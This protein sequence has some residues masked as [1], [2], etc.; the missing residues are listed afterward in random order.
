[1]PAQF[2]PETRDDVTGW[3]WEGPFATLIREAIPGIAGTDLRRAREYLNACGMVVNVRAGQ[4]GA[5]PQWFIRACWHQGPGGHVHVVTPARPGQAAEPPA[6]CDASRAPQGNGCHKRA[7]AG[8]PGSEAGC[9]DRNTQWHAGSAAG[10]LRGSDGDGDTWFCPA[11]RGSRSSGPPRNPDQAAGANRSAA[12]APIPADLG[13]H[14]PHRGQCARTGAP[15][16]VVSCSRM[17][18]VRCSR[19]PVKHCELWL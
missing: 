18:A 11:S 16:G 10:P 17:S 9:G 5:Q 14:D 1:M 12:D 7:A 3:L 6:A 15:A 8:W 13:D 2:T 4:R 19:M